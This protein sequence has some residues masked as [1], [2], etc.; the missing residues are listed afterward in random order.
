MFAPPP[1]A[2]AFY[3]D[4]A[5]RAG[6]GRVLELAC[7]SGLLTV[8]LARALSA[9]GGEVVGLDLAPAMIGAARER[10]AAAGVRAAFVEGD[11][12]HFDLGA[13]RFDLIFIPFN[14]L[15]HLHAADELLAC[16]ACVRRQL[17][18][19]GAFAFDIFNPSVEFLA[20]APDVRV[21]FKRVA[22][23]TLGELAIEYASEYDAAAQVG[24]STWYFSAP[25][26]P[27]ALTMQLA[28]RSIFP[29][30]LPLLLAAGGLRLEARYGDLDRSPFASASRRQVCVCRAER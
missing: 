16:F 18:P 12:R 25:D 29:Q 4:E 20:R 21:A 1:G 22:H 9:E 14:S 11:M 2:L 24:R 23:P 19:G 15:L 30:E 13:A 10:A 5:R 17:A 27:D 7:G 28:L 26:R 3:L 6:A 8:P